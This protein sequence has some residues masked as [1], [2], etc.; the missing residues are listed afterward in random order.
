MLR[1]YSADIPDFN[2]DNQPIVRVEKR[3]TYRVAFQASYLITQQI[4]FNISVGK[5]FDSPFNANAGFFSIFGLNYSVFN[6]EKV[7]L[8]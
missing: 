2:I 7:K 3:F 6:T 8:K 5:D 4:S 1:W